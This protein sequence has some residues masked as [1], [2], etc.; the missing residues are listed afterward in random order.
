VIP[1]AAFR[2]G[3]TLNRASR[4][5]RLLWLF[6]V[7]G[8]HVGPL[9]GLLEIAG[10]RELLE[11]L[12]TEGDAWAPADL[13]A[14]LHELG[15]LRLVEVAWPWVRLPGVTKANPP[16]NPNVLK[17]WGARFADVADSPLKARLYSEIEQAVGAMSASFGSALA[18]SFAEP[19]SSADG[20][21]LTP[22]PAKRE[23]KR[24]RKLP[25]AYSAQEL[26]DDWASICV[27]AGLPGVEHGLGRTHWPR[28][29]A[30]CRDLGT[31]ERG[32][33]LLEALAASPFHRGR[34]RN[35]KPTTI[36][37]VLSDRFDWRDEIARN[38]RSAHDD[39]RRL[40]PRA[41]DHAGADACLA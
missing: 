39:D 35:S 12:S 32:R 8:P 26:L 40:G 20:F 30:L 4:P 2:T 9:P 6:L 28:A 33:E 22:Q 24:Q 5:A 38:G 19:E 41:A 29:A 3:S 13:E 7:G 25:G 14:A 36:Y 10:P 21:E 31:R 16:N 18:A 27:P 37:Q 15:E 1:S 11:S 23:R 34:N 17:G